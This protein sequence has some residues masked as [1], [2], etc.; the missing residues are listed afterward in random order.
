[1]QKVPK[2]VTVISEMT[3][4]FFFKILIFLLTIPTKYCK[5][6][7]KICEVN[8]TIVFGFGI[9][10]RSVREASPGDSKMND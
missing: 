2:K 1:M 4:T 7:Q 8:L 9:I 5:L 10:D 6:K 3:V